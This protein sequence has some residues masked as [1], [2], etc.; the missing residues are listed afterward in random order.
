MSVGVAY[1]SSVVDFKDNF[2]PQLLDGNTL[3]ANRKIL[4]TGTHLHHDEQY[5]MSTVYDLL[6]EIKDPEHNH[7]LEELQIISP[8]S[9]RLSSSLIA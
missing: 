6:S 8:S 4:D 1:K 3:A 2:T 7:T 9:I 5:L